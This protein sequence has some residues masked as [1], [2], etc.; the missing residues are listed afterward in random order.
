MLKPSSRK[1]LFHCVRRWDVNR[2][3]GYLERMTRFIYT[4]TTNLLNYIYNTYV[5]YIYKYQLAHFWHCW[6][7]TQKVIYHCR[8]VVLDD[9]DQFNKRNQQPV[10]WSNIVYYEK[11]CK[12][13]DSAWLLWN[14]AQKRSYNSENIAASILQCTHL[15]IVSLITQEGLLN[16]KIRTH[17]LMKYSDNNPYIWFHGPAWI[18]STSTRHCIFSKKQQN[19]DKWPKTK[20]RK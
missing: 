17:D 16:T 8:L 18:Q 1:V 10:L 13:C 7:Q 20:A 5:M 6:I 11:P 9:S 4:A 3:T 15:Q 2:V 19:N 12:G 14:T